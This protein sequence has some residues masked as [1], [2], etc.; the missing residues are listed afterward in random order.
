MAKAGEFESQRKPQ[1]VIIE[2]IWGK[3]GIRPFCCI[4]YRIEYYEE[5]AVTAFIINDIWGEESGSHY[6]QIMFVTCA[7]KKSGA[8]FVFFLYTQITTL[9]QHIYGRPSSDTYKDD[10]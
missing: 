5:S 1:I 10:K 7:H 3:K 4:S 8:S 9:Q 6:L 2:E